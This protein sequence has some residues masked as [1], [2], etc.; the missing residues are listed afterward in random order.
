[1]LL[2]TH[3]GI[4]WHRALG[5]GAHAVNV[6]VIGRPEND[7]TTNVW[8]AILTAAPELQVEFIPVHYDAETLAREMEGEGLPPEFAETI[9]T[10]WWTTCLQNRPAKERARGEVLEAPA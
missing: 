4:K 10:G 2:C 8:Y 9:R 3:T 5:G 6:G 7:G 1:V